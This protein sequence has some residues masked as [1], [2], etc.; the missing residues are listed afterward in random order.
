MAYAPYM[1]PPNH[2]IVGLLRDLNKPEELEEI[3]HMI[4]TNH[5]IIGSLFN[6]L[7]RAIVNVG[8][9]FVKEKVRR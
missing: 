3:P 6:H 8:P 1:N 9:L 7:E 5:G 2:G 4:P